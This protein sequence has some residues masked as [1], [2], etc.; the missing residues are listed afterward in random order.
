MLNYLSLPFPPKVSYCLRNVFNAFHQCLEGLKVRRPWRKL[1]AFYLCWFWS[2]I[3]YLVNSGCVMNLMFSQCCVLIFSD[4][5]FWSVWLD[6]GYNWSSFQKVF[7]SSVHWTPTNPESN[8]DLTQ[9]KSLFAQNN[10]LTPDTSLHPHILFL[11]TVLLSQQSSV[12]LKPS[13]IYITRTMAAGWFIFKSFWWVNLMDGC[14]LRKPDMCRKETFKSIP[15]QH[16]NI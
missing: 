6:F 16:E 8:S 13:H 14:N 3:I 11:V 15:F 12:S 2:W 4:G 1:T 7:W 5:H 10:S 9:R